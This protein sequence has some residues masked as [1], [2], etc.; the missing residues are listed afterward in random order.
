MVEASLIADVIW[1]VHPATL[2]Y[3]AWERSTA[4]EFCPPAKLE[5]KFQSLKTANPSGVPR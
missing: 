1:A 3:R 5:A 4:D 2:E